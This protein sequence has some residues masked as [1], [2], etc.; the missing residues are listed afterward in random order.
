LTIVITRVRIN[1]P[2]VGDILGLEGQMGVVDFVIEVRV[3]VADFNWTCN[4][5]SFNNGR[6]VESVVLRILF[7]LRLMSS[8]LLWSRLSLLIRV[9]NFELCEIDVI[10]LVWLR[11]LP[12]L[13]SMLMRHHCTVHEFG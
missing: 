2:L 12:I 9:H 5:L 13:D 3:R 11:L 10:L 8:D 4:F 7:R 1:E 6:W